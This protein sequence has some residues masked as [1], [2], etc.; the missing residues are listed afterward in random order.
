MVHACLTRVARQ[1]PGGHPCSLC[2]KK[3]RYAHIRSTAPHPPPRPPYHHYIR[4][5]HRILLPARVE[6]QR[7][8]LR[9]KAGRQGGHKIQAWQGGGERV[10]THT[11][12]ALPWAV[13]TSPQCNTPASTHAHTRTHLVIVVILHIRLIVCVLYNLF[14]L[15]L[16][17]LLPCA[18]VCFLVQYVQP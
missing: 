5:R 7:V 14:R 9:Y 12:S 13:A 16:L 4:H 18:P 8:G 15:L 3:S 11:C 10:R 2:Y 17:I 1:T 6:M